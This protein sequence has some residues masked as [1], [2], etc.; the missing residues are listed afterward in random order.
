[1]GTELIN[2]RGGRIYTD[3]YVISF[4]LHLAERYGWKARGPIAPVYDPSR[5]WTEEYYA[6]L[7]QLIA[8]EDAEALAKAL[9]KAL[10]DPGRKEIE[11]QEAAEL[12]EIVSKILS[13]DCTIP[14]PKD[15][16]PLEKLIGFTSKGPFVIVWDDLRDI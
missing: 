6:E 16:E 14:P 2:A 9:E 11:K 5:G 13:R 8:K 12:S 7:L 10:L 15:I 1:M 3:P 4:Y